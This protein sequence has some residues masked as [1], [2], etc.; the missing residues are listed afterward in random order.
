ML[1]FGRAP[2]E[3]SAMQSRVHLGLSLVPF[4]AALLVSGC[5]T[6]DKQDE[7]D[8]SLLPVA[9]AD[10]IPAASTAAP[11]VIAPTPVPVPV[12]VGTTV[13]P[14]AGA[15]TDAGAPKPADAGAAA[16][17]TFKACS[18]K[19]QALLAGCAIPT[20]PKDGGL[21][22]IKDPVACQAAANACVAACTP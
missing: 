15:P 17:G 1:A 8:A 20:F 10:P 19:C 2:G 22:Q 14:D 13:K 21:P 3:V 4:L 7:P 5:T 16:N 18:E 9:T 11:T 6:A 12:P